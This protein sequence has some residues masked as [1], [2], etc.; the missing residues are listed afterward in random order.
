[1]SISAFDTIAADFEGLRALPAGLPAAIRDAVWDALGPESAHRVLEI[2]AGTGRIGQA[3][4][5]TG[6]RYIAV[7][8]SAMMLARFAQ[9]AGASYTSTV[10][11]V[12]ADGRSLPFADGSFDAVLLV[13]VISGSPGWRQIL[14]DARRV[15]SPGGAIVLGRATAPPEGIDQRMRT[16]LS[17]LLAEAGVDAR[18]P[19]ADRNE[20]CDWL[21][22]S[23][24]RSVEVIAGRW[25]AERSPRDF[26]LRHA[27]G[28]R[29]AALDQSTRDEA[30]RRL[31]DWA[32]NTF[33]DLDAKFI[34]MH[35][36]VLDI[37]VF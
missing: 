10:S 21:G 3:F 9:K 20:S 36:F 26:L 6:D 34:E 30:L 13:Q 17:F 11:L 28:A 5:A 8:S 4:L 32:T 25:E 18:R 29:F 15:L 2:G 31:A 35:S 33:G 7:D 37:F 16:Q 27:S 14:T 19:G 23:A 22:A 1:M 12:L 24:R